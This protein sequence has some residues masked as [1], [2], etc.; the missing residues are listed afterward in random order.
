MGDILCCRVGSDYY[1]EP[2]LP[3]AHSYLDTGK[4]KREGKE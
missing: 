3:F 2:S 1:K 4:A